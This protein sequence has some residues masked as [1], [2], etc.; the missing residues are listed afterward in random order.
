MSASDAAPLPRLG[1]VFFDVRGNSRTMRLSWYADT[2]VA[3]FSIWQGGMCTG[4]FRLPMGDLSRMVEILQRGPDKRDERGAGERG[5]PAPRQDRYAD[6]G[7]D[8][9]D[10][11]DYQPA[12][13]QPADY[14]DAGGYQD[15]GYRGTD[16]YGAGAYGGP[17][18]GPGQHGAGQHDAGQYGPDYGEHEPGYA[19]PGYGD[20]SYGDQSYD[21]PRYEP[22]YEQEP[23][24]R[25]RARPPDEG[26][27]QPDA[28]GQRFVPPYVQAQPDPS[29]SDYL[30][31]AEYGQPAD[32][33][34][35]ARHS[36]GRHSGGHPQ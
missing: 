9:G 36:A 14:Q 17:A 11:A 8:H 10:Y 26:R 31:D 30:E 22:Q 18:Y 27:Y 5:D 4:T 35:G 12:D 34:A 16:N 24:G 6:A 1:E 25:R 33:G 15:P 2:D 29:Q 7:Y 20:H 21:E 23:R 19:E 13:Y 28:T 32:P 3:V